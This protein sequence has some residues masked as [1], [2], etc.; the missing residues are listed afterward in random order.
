[1]H[2]GWKTVALQ[3]MCKSAGA[4][5]GEGGQIRKLQNR[6]TYML[7]CRGNAENQSMA[8]NKWKIKK[9]LW[10]ILVQ[11]AKVQNSGQF[12]KLCILLCVNVC[13]QKTLGNNYIKGT[14]A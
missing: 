2:A 12:P 8:L 9:R 5:S 1:V 6:T 3:K 14:V 11:W 7:H 13:F 4:N 10:S